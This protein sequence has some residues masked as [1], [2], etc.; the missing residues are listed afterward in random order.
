MDAASSIFRA[1]RPRSPS[2]VFSVFPR[3]SF[4]LFPRLRTLL[5]AFPP[6]PLEGGLHDRLNGLSPDFDF[7]ADSR[8]DSGSCRKN[9][10]HNSYR[11]N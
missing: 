9:R 8:P 6:V 5:N 3:N 4:S 11:E 2:E 7:T 10:K 1:K